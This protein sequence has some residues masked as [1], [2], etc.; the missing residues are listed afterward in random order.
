MFVKLTQNQ[1]HHAVRLSN[2]FTLDIAKYSWLCANTGCGHV[3]A[4]ASNDG[5]VK[6]LELKSGQLSSLVG[7][8]DDVQCVVFDHKAEHLLSGGADGTVRLWT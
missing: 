8:E 2:N 3:I 6:V 7:H 5:T 1:I 4:L